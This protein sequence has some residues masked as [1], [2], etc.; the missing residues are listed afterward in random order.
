MKYMNFKVSGLSN[1]PYESAEDNFTGRDLFV[2]PRRRDVSNTPKKPFS[3]CTVSD[4]RLQL[5]SSV[6]L[7]NQRDLNSAKSTISRYSHF[8]VTS[9]PNL[10]AEITV[11]M[12]FND[13]GT[14]SELQEYN[15]TPRDKVNQ[16]EHFL[17]NQTMQLFQQVIFLAMVT[18]ALPWKWN[19]KTCRIEKYGP[20]LYKI[21]WFTWIWGT[22]INIAIGV[23]LIHT[24]LRVVK[25]AE[26]YRQAFQ[27]CLSGCKAVYA[28]CLRIYLFIYKE[29]VSA[30][31]IIN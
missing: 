23:Y 17:D 10:N 18:G 7:Q 15:Q 8:S 20:M 19:R 21:W 30:I 4:T 6:L 25:V 11:D 2:D 31:F 28:L 16:R 12:E 3:V 26:T 1:Y 22:I 14:Y 5:S 29:P 24:L 27:L 9:D 13:N